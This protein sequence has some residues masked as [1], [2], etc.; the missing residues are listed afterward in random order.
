MSES[1]ILEFTQSL[2][3]KGDFKAAEETLR[4]RMK[5]PPAPLGAHLLMTD[6]LI[7]QSKHAEVAQF[8]N[9]HP[10]NAEIF[11]RLRDY[12]VGERM[13][14]AAMAL[15]AKSRFSDPSIAHINDSIRKQLSGDLPGAIAACNNALRFNAEDASAYN[16]LGRVLFNAGHPSQ[17][18]SAFEK[19]LALKPDFAE[20]WHNQGYVF[21]TQNKLDESEKAYERSVE[22]APY[23]RSALLNLAIVKFSR[24]K[25]ADALACLHKLLDQ[26]PNHVEAHLNAGIGEHILQNTAQAKFH[27]LKA[28]ALDPKSDIAM[29]HLASLYSDEQDTKSAVEY[30]NK[31]L[32]INP[33]V[34]EVWAELIRIDERNNQLE[35]AQT[36]LNKAKR[37]LPDD[38]NVLYM[39]AILARRHNQNN[40]SLAL[41]KRIDPRLL[42]PRFFQP[43]Y[44]EIAT[45]LDSVGDYG[46][47][48]RAFEK[49]NEVASQNTRAQQVDFSAFD[50]Q[51]DVIEEW[52]ANGAKQDN[53][54][55]HEDLGED[56]CFL[57][58]FPRS[59]TT[60]LDV[61][62]DGHPN[63]Q[64]LEERGSIEH[65]AFVIDQELEGYPTALSKFSSTQRDALREQY[66]AYLENEGLRPDS[67]GIVV[68][69]MPIRTIH[70]ALIHRLF[71]RA[72]F[73]FV[74]RHPCDVI[75]S[76]FMQ[77]FSANKAFV[78]FNSLAECT[79][80]YERVMRI[81]KT[82]NSLMPI[83]VH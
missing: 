22:I 65:I 63:T 49:A 17:S 82:T 14:E 8:V 48:F 10:D 57:L 56:L 64:I 78:H 6:I 33:K 38:T 24:G 37:I 27:Y 79:R 71:P 20:A 23:F 31:A 45:A 72:K 29:R 51:M 62:L 83:P 73:L 53:Y 70:A 41:F 4:M 5:M 43:Y 52:L 81:W 25:N 18:Q 54:E 44:F 61:M 32:A 42:H 67:G 12:F 11:I 36:N 58:G 39:S 16:Q 7:H 26:D 80:I 60:L 28:I 1:N 66:R 59:G 15:I 74:V 76:N 19:S 55:K 68:D 35:L 77:N 3:A 2:M 47:A 46:N 13:N 40:E 50:R 75:L 34:G 30:L 69:K 9:E 21:R